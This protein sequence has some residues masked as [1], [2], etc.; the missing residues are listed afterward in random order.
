[1]NNKLKLRMYILLMVTVVVLI[2]GVFG[3]V[4]VISRNAMLDDIRER[5]VGVKE[6]ILTM[7]YAEDIIDIGQS[8][9][10]GIRAA[11]QIQTIGDRLAGIGN[12]S[13]LYLATLDDEGSIITSLMALGDDFVPTGEAADDLRRSLRDDV[14]VMGRRIYRTQDGN[15]YTIF[16]PARNQAG[17]L[18]GVV[19]ME[20]STENIFALHREAAV[21]SLALSA[22]LLALISI[23]AYVSINRVAEPIYKKL[24][25]NDMMTGYENRM[26]F[27]HRL[28]E[29]ARLAEA[30][31]KITLMICDMN[32]L[33]VVNDE[34]GHNEGD[35]YLKNT[36]DIIFEHLDGKGSL[37]RIGGDEFACIL[38]EVPDDEVMRIINGLR[39]EERMA[40]PLQR[41]SCACGYATYD[42][43]KD[44]TIRDLFKRADVDMYKEKKRIKSGEQ[45]PLNSR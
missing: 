7:I 43:E 45:S 16:W 10:E 37:Y 39:T 25:Y 8:T 30:G 21:Y 14:A 41:F 12:L 11:T 6:Y 24:A 40:H 31:K 26:A 1:M 34:H 35:V 22:V 32:N 15:V 23:I 33:K 36:A 13:R 28:R 19:S 3:M 2:G 4:Y 42:P 5:A 27:E 18:L 29:C 17:E 9:P 20:F 44:N 38:T